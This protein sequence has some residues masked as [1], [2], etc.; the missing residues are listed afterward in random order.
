MRI[1]T[2]LT[3][4]QIIAAKP[5]VKP[6]K[7]GMKAVKTNGK[8]YALWDGGGLHIIIKPNGSKLWRFQFVVAGKKSL[9]GLGEYPAVSLAAARDKAGDLRG[10]VRQNINPVV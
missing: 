7:P 3:D 2:P 6:A 4:K 9:M 5:G 10:L 8:E 1:V